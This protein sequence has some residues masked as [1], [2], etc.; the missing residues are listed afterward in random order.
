MSS[1]WTIIIVCHTVSCY[2]TLLEN[3]K[4]LRNAKLWFLF[5]FVA[6]PHCRASQLKMRTN[7]K[8]VIVT[9]T[10]QKKS[11]PVAKKQKKKSGNLG[12][13]VYLL[14]VKKKIQQTA[15]QPNV[16]QHSNTTDYSETASLAVAK[17]SHLF[18]YIVKKTW[19]KMTISHYMKSCVTGQFLDLKKQ[20]VFCMN[21][22]L[23]M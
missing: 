5:L 17:N 10:V 6:I 23:F 18:T 12:K 14:S 13:F 7:L 19:I 21:V 9:M 15:G 20:T 22:G 11:T 8:T 2:L 1:Y 4:G 16:S 3:Q